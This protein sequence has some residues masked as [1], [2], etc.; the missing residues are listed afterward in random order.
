M[1]C[2]LCIGSN[3]KQEENVRFARQRLSEHFPSIRFAPE[4]ETVPFGLQNPSPF[5]NQVAW[6]E[7]S[8][9]EPEVRAILK[10]IEREAG[11][12]AAD[13]EKEIVR[14]DIDLLS[15]DEQVLKPRDMQYDYVQRGIGYLKRLKK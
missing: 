3:C 13:K 5:L 2:L 14:L 8:R 11:R 9:S 10:E 1:I 12:S 7:T 4:E 6:L 15:C